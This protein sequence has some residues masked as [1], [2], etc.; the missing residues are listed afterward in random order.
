MKPLTN[1]EYCQHKKMTPLFAREI[2]LAT[3]QTKYELIDL[4]CAEWLGAKTLEKEIPRARFQYRCGVCDL[5]VSEC[6]WGDENWTLHDA[7]QFNYCPRCGQRIDWDH[8]ELYDREQVMFPS[9]YENPDRVAEKRK[10][11]EDD[12]DFWW[13]QDTVFGTPRWYFNRYGMWKEKADWQTKEDNH[14]L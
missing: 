1:D 9:E 8:D 13:A 5:D 2:L 3:N 12:N 6:D 4:M 10:K 11:L 7:N 14:E